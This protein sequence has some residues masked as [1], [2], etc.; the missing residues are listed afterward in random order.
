MQ[1]EVLLPTSDQRRLGTSPPP[2]PLQAAVYYRECAALLNAPPLNQVCVWRPGAA[3]AHQAAPV[4]QPSAPHPHPTPWAPPLFGHS[5]LTT[6]RPTPLQHFDRS[7]L[8]HATVKG[9]L[10]EVEGTVQNSAALRDA[11]EFAGVAKEIARLRVGGG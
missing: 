2:T 6:L 3:W 1:N 10:Y 9:L 7:W 11:D 4:S 5:R 8:A